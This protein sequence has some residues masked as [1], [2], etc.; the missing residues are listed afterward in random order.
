MGKRNASPKVTIEF[1]S[2]EVLPFNGRR[3]ERQAEAF[4]Q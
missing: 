2:G 1:P 4:T 3:D